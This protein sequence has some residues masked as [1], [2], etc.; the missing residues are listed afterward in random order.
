M[1][2]W[3]SFTSQRLA[4]VEFAD[5]TLWGATQFLKLTGTAAAETISGDTLINAND[6][7][8]GGAGNDTLIGYA[9]VDTLI[10]GTGDDT[11]YAQSSVGYNTNGTA[12]TADDLTGGTG[13]DYLVGT[14]GANIYRYNLGDGADTINAAGD[15]NVAG[16]A[17]DKLILG[18]GIAAANITLTRTSNDLIIKFS[19]AGDQITLT[20][21]YSYVSQQLT[22][23]TFSDG[24][25]FSFL[26]LAGTADIDF[27]MGTGGADSLNGGMSGGLGNDIYL[28]D[29][30]GDIVT[31]ALNAGA[32]TVNTS[33]T[34]VLGANVENLTLTGTTAINGT[35][36]ADNNIIIGSDGNNL[37]DGL[38]G[39][40]TMK[41]GLG[42]DT[43]NIDVLT[44]VV[45]E[46]LNEGTDL[47]NV[48]VAVAGGTYTVAANVENA[49]LT[50]TVAYNLT[51]NALDNVLIGNAAANTLIGGAGN[52][53]LDGLG[54]IDSMSGGLGNDTYVLDVAGDV[55]N[56]LAGEGT[57]TVKTV[58]TYSLTSTLENLTLLGAAAIN[59]TGNTFDNVLIGNSAINTLSGNDG[60]DTLDGAGAAD[61]LI[62]GLGNDTYVVDVATDAI[63]EALNAGTDLVQSSAASYAL[64][65]NIENLTLTGTGAINGTG[66]AL[67]NTIV[68]NTAANIIDGGTG[69]DTLTGGLGNDTY[70]V[71]TTTDVINELLNQGIDTI[72][73][74]ATFSLANFAYIENITLTGAAVI[75]A[76]GN[77]LDNV[78]TGNSAANVLTGG[79][80]N[81]TYVVAATND[82]IAELLN[83]GVDIVQSSVT[84]SLAAIAHLENLTLTGAA[85]IN[86]TGNA[87]DN[88]LIGNSAANVLTG[89]DGNDTLDGLGGID[90]MSGGLGNDIYVVDL[91][92]DVVTETLSAGIDTIQSS[93][94]LASLAA[95]V[96]NLILTGS[97]AING[98]GNALDNLL[99]GNTGANSISGGDGN[100]TIDGGTGI[101]TMAGGAGNDVYFVNVATDVVTEVLNEGTDTINSAVTFS[102]DLLTNVENLTLTGTT[103]INGTGNSLNNTL[104]GGN[105]NNILTGGTGMDVLTGGLGADTFDFNLITESLVGAGRDIIAD[106]NRVQLDKI[107]LSTIDADSVLA[108][109]QAF[110]SSILTNGAFTAIGQ[111]R[112]VGDILSGNTDS[113]FATSEFEI[114]LTGVTSLVGADFVL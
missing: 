43:Y 52:D 16:A 4:S 66:N 41:G 69:I 71:D 53:T 64:A 58:F 106:F 35:G 42:N 29:N 112:L 67:A 63:T 13:N 103:A 1:T 15:S 27:M 8:D 113:N 14:G 7:I 20:G 91:A 11:L 111:L 17:V 80:G 39:N 73:S 96:E 3:Y 86:G 2:G 79:A 54:G 83:E 88:I 109:D 89:N 55:I 65:V 93:V 22:S 6:V 59:G 32:D 107:D 37:I 60:N 24:S 114:Q 85:I 30:I 77:A 57:D 95:N 21:W 18:V 92:T 101:D 33:L 90:N 78:I 5:S 105:G 51:G 28:V 100:D 45:T 68:G 108:N 110:L 36:N 76:T 99:T 9:G 94:T 75:N 38:V 87:L 56:E 49:T 12:T 84:F 25:V 61:I 10:G 26:S 46:N 40:D 82:T 74:T 19:N 34:Y 47:I 104:T 102:L 62:G 98:V 50:N 70:I 81:D 72:Q 48:T 44:D 31:E 97:G 23:I